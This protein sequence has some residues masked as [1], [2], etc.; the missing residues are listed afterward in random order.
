MDAGTWIEITRSWI[1]AAV[2]RR[3]R[4]VRCHRLW[5]TDDAPSPDAVS[6]DIRAA[7]EPLGP[8][9]GR[10]AVLWSAPGVAV[11]LCTPPLP[12]APGLRAA[13][14]SHAAAAG[15]TPGNDP[16]GAASIT[17][18]NRS[19]TP[20]AA[21]ASHIV[22]AG[23]A[24]PLWQAIRRG[25]TD[26]GGTLA[27][28]HSAQA[29]TLR[30]V[31]LLAL[32]AA[33]EP[34]T[35]A[36]GIDED[37]SAIA[38]AA[39][40]QIVLARTVDLGASALRRSYEH[41]L[42]TTGAADAEPGA[43][44]I[45]ERADAALR[46]HG[47]PATNDALPSGA[48]ADIVFQMM[49]PALQRL[50]FEVKQSIR[51]SASDDA[52]PEDAARCTPTLRLTDAA[53]P[54]LAGLLA[55]E[56][57]A[58]LG[59]IPSAA[60][61]APGARL[62]RAIT[63]DHALFAL[64]PPVNHRAGAASRT[65]WALAAGSACALALVAADATLTDARARE[66]AQHAEALEARLDHTHQPEAREIHDAAAVRDFTAIIHREIGPAAPWAGA[67]AAAAAELRPDFRLTRVAGDRSA[68]R[69]ILRLEGELSAPTAADAQAALADAVRR[70]RAIPMFAQVDVPAIDQETVSNGAVLTFAVQITLKETTPAWVAEVSP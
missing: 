22:V 23:M 63:A 6:A 33:H 36:V 58:R 1:D 46:A 12:G 20:H 49:R 5:R 2:V 52:G 47:V 45:A 15:L 68:E 40:G 62:L 14:L 57:S 17:Q 31:A 29:T 7:I 38:I 56:C 21:S 64:D 34:L 54:N 55:K 30:D 32:G 4:I 70:F 28:V 16:I 25:I 42:R 10:I 41:A 35:V 67:L 50:V 43:P 18:R 48:S 53:V 8:K 26:A 37:G 24:A 60:D 3:G 44:S 11:D 13:R 27:A 59:T 19:G 39:D 51:F 69:S 9:P 65:R 66:A 61:H